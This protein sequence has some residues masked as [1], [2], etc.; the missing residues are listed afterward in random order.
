[1]FHLTFVCVLY[2]INK[3][4]TPMIAQASGQGAQAPILIVKKTADTVQ[5]GRFPPTRFFLISR[6]FIY[7]FYFPFLC[8]CNHFVGSL[9]CSL[10]HLTPTLPLKVWSHAVQDET[11]A[12]E[13]FRAVEWQT[14]TT[15]RRERRPNGLPFVFDEISRLLLC[16]F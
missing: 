16:F 9:V 7:I 2:M 4:Y 14:A 5:C 12:S 13:V 1:M 10:A 3:M 8:A 15:S 6:S 11:R